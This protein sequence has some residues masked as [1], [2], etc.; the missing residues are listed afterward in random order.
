MT[1]AV[2]ELDERETPLLSVILPG[3]DIAF[4]ANGSGSERVRTEGGFNEGRPL[5]ASE[6]VWSF[7]ES[8]PE[9]TVE[10]TD[11]E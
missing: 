8:L 4:T 10:E 3:T 2:T 7:M 9:R 5:G 11:L 1:S 6:G